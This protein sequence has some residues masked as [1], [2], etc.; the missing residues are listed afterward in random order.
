MVKVRVWTT[1][2]TLYCWK[3]QQ[4]SRERPDEIGARSLADEL[5]SLT[6]LRAEEGSW[7]RF[8]MMALI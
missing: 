1:Q 8:T 3:G 5:V 2:W 7:L 4:N 6:G